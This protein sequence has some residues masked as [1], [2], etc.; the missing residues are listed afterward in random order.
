MNKTERAIKKASNFIINGN[1]SK[2]FMSL[3]INAPTWDRAASFTKQK[4]RFDFGFRYFVQIY[5]NVCYTHARTHIAHRLTALAMP[6]TTAH[7][8]RY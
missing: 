7:T 2:S 3:L 4:S 8:F 5:I 6:T 1:G